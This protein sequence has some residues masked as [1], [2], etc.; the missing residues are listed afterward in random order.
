MKT[1]KSPP[2]PLDKFIRDKHGKIATWQRPN[3]PIVGWFV[4]AATAHLFHA[5]HLRTGL[6]FISSA[7]LFTWAYL[8]LRHGASYF[9]RSLGLVVLFW[10]AASHFK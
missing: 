7:F 3:L 4:F 10:V 2:S 6:E 1:R 8:E 9:R 5:G